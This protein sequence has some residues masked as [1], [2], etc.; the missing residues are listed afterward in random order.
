MDK[1]YGLRVERTRCSDTDV[2]QMKLVREVSDG[3]FDV[4]DD[5]PWTSD[6]ISREGQLL[7]DLLMINDGDACLCTA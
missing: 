7:D 4:R 5:L 6:R 3:A 1:T 2:R